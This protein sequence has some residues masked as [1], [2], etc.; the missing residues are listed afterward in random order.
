MFSKGKK[1]E[2]GEKDQGSD[3][4]MKDKAKNEERKVDGSRWSKK[5]N[6]EQGKEMGG[7]NTM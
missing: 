6:T 7:K 5:K 2:S 3:K 1:N 4:E